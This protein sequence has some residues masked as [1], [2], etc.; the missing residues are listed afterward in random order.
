[1]NG[2]PRRTP[3]THPPAP[4]TVAV[5]R[6][7]SRHPEWWVV[8]AA[9]VAWV[10]LLW[11]VPTEVPTGVPTVEV[12]TVGAA[13]HGAL[14]AAAH[15]PAPSSPPWSAAVLGSGATAWLLMVLAMMGPVMVPRVRHVAATCVGRVRAA[16]TAATVAGALLVWSVVGVGV[17]GASAVGL[18][19][20]P[21][22]M[23]LA[24]AGV[25]LLVA[26]YQLSPAKATAL[27]RCHAIRVPRGEADG[28]GRLTAGVA[29]SGWCVVSC[30]PAMVAMALTRHSLLLMVVLTVGLTA[31]RVAHRPRRAVRRLAAAVAVSFAL[32]A[33]AGGAHVLA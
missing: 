2:I 18:T 9:A 15:G 1:V 31:E 29:Y 20:D 17:I 13:D 16:A 11:T 27:S 5:A 12:P 25:G 19:L 24:V 4:L 14:H 8:L 6:F 26:A 28:L 7:T 3:G 21:G 23:P 22:R 30:G 33:V 32:A 10:A